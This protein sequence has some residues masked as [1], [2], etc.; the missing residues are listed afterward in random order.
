[1]TVPPHPH[2][3]SGGYFVW[4]DLPQPLRASDLARRA[5]EEEN[6]RIA[7]GDLFQV[8][9]EVS[10]Y[11]DDFEGSVRICF[12]WEEPSKLEEGIQRLAALVQRA[13][14]STAERS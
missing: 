3:V 1:M 8:Q 9:G 2:E 11:H 10:P 14:S 12:A 5:M 13:I 6:L 4:I 7:S